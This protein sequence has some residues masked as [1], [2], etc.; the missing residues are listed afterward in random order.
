MH[1]YWN[2]AWIPSFALAVLLVHKHSSFNVLEARGVGV[3][4]LNSRDRYRAFSMGDDLMLE[5]VA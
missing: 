4:T 3:K 2:S 1:A 5:T